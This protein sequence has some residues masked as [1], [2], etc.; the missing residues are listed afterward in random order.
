[1]REPV[2]RERLY[3]AATAEECD[4]EGNPLH[5][6]I[7]VTDYIECHY[8]GELNLEA[9]M[10]YPIA[11]HFGA[12]L[13]DTRNYKEVMKMPDAKQWEEALRTEMKQLERLGVFIAP[14]PLPYGAK[15]IKT[16]VI[17]KKKLF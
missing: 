4:V 16:R 3:M 9:L 14:C 12:L 17:L 5:I 15:K 13:D 1:M 6:F 7:S 2:E 11:S 8:T 10:G